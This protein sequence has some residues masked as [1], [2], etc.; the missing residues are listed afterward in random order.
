LNTGDGYELYRN[1]K[2]IA[3]LKENTNVSY[4]DKGLTAGNT[5]QYRVRMYKEA[6]KDSDASKMVKL[7]GALSDAVSVTVSA[8]Q[9]VLNKDNCSVS[10]NQIKTAWKKQTGVSGY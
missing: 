6:P 5:Y 8:G 7:Y 3:T 4:E 10:G 1:D 9:V 2:L